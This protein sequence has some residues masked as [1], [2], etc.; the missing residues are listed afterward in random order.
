M[1]EG[2]QLPGGLLL[3]G[4]VIAAVVLIAALV[5]AYLRSRDAG[6]DTSLLD[7]VLQLGALGLA[8]W[9]AISLLW[10]LVDDAESLLLPLKIMGV[11]MIFFAVGIAFAFGLSFVT[12]LLGRA[13]RR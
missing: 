2:Y 1:D 13:S 10:I 11:T 3:I 12:G 8:G 7:R 9:V 4:I 5:R 6:Q